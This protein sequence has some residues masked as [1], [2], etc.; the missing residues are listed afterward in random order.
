MPVSDYALEVIAAGIVFCWK[1]SI[2]SPRQAFLRVLHARLA[3]APEF[4]DGIAW[5]NPGRDS[6]ILAQKS[7]FPREGA[8]N[9]RLLADGDSPGSRGSLSITTFDWGEAERIRYKAR[10]ENQGQ[11]A[12]RKPA[13]PVLPQETKTQRAGNESQP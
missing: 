10:K 1:R 4:P 3:G 7:I 5:R 12:M 6:S 11:K 9:G 2:G 8:G 13:C